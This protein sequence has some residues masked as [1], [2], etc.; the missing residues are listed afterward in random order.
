[1][2]R[3]GWKPHKVRRLEGARVITPLS[4]QLEVQMKAT[5]DPKYGIDAKG[6]ICNIATGV[7][8]PED[9]PIF[10]LRA[11]D[12]LAEQTL[13]FYL[14]MVPTNE[15]QDAVCFRIDDFRGFRYL[16]RDRMKAPDTIFPYPKHKVID[17]C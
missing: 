6:R 2:I 13:H 5:Q 7:P 1:M 8:I 4:L 17:D 10:I 3:D 12:E 15:H 11:K 16:K 14:S 9:E